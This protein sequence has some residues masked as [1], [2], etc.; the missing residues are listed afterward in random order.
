MPAAFALSD[1]VIGNP[2]VA[3]FAAFGSFASLLLVDFGGPIV[4]RLQAMAAMAVAGGVLIC[5]GTLASRSAVLAAVA[6]ACVGF[7]ILFAGVVSSVLASATTALLLL[8]ILPVSLSGPV[9]SIPDRLAGWGI[10]V[11]AALLAIGLLWPAPAHDPLRPPSIKALRALAARLRLDAAMARGGGSAPS[12]EAH[13]AASQQADDAVH[14]L[15]QA[16]FA[17][18]YRPTGLTTTARLLV[19]LVDELNW[20][21][22][23]VVRSAPKPGDPP[24]HPLACSVKS[25]AASLLDQGAD[26]LDRPGA[27]PDDLRAGVVSLREILEEVERVTTR[28]LPARIAA[29]GASEGSPSGDIA[30]AEPIGEFVSSLD[31]SFRAQEL[32]F[33]V[34]QI[35]TNID[36]ATVTERRPWLDRLI[37][38]QPAG[39]SGRLST[40]HMRAAAA[41]ERHSVWLHNSLRGATGLGLA[42][43]VAQLTGV[44]H[45][46]WVVFGALSVLRSNALSTGQNVLRGLLGTVVGFIVGAALIELIGTDTTVLWVLLPFAV[47]FA[48]LAPAA[49]SFAA[50]Q[51]GF[52]LTL[53]ILFNILAPLGWRVGLVR[54][55]DVTIGCAVSLAVGILFWPRGAGGA[56]GT[57]LADAYADSVRYLSAA[58]AFGVARC[59]S[60]GPPQAAPTVEA[61]AAS[62]ASQR[63]D[64]AFRGYLT[65]RGAKRVPLAE[66]TG[67]VTGVVGL[68]LA[69]D[70]V[71]DLWHQDDGN[72]G[73]RA[74]A[75]EQ[76]L[77]GGE[78]LVDWYRRF[79][80]SLTGPAD[81]PEPLPAGAVSDGR[82]VEAVDRDLRGSDGHATATAVRVIWTGDH[83]DAARRLQ[84]SLVGPA[85][86]ANEERA[87]MPERHAMAL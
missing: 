1:K 79:A 50:G 25:G 66:V 54:I 23:I 71:L 34:S 75:R 55:E 85:R 73:D 6:M 33:V 61:T 18:P 68:R 40:A 32:S 15:R 62:A 51:A 28:K 67:L 10:A 47:L 53:L 26:L 49:I 19:R 42:V 77:A 44:Q 22:A 60:A 63:L 35:A 58:V 31:P 59:D 83:L 84:A 8:F 78:A 87:L 46:F 29:A 20:L 45:S 43:L 82:L 30:T 2:T 21:N 3:T 69:G 36:L 81:V 5:L 64:D 11:S 16:F 70:A 80:D 27:S 38:R 4:D 48:G 39:V 37:G 65:E 74:A 12:A 17:T 7:A 76:L 57:A 9:S 14:A 86:I 13:A 72:G 41:L 52:T 56:L 24:V